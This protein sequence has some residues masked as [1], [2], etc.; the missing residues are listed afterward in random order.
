MKYYT[1][2]DIESYVVFTILLELIFFFSGM[3]H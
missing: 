3:H 1:D 2:L